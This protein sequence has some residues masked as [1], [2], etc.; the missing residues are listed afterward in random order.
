MGINLDVLTIK[1]E[2]IKL[3][4]ASKFA[5]FRSW[6]HFSNLGILNRM[7]LVSKF[8]IFG[9]FSTKWVEIT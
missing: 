1:F 3:E 9:P 2:R 5:I 4:M 7:S 8:N 6:V